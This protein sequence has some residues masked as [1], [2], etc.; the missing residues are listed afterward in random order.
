[1]SIQDLANIA[2]LLGVLV[3][4]IIFIIQSRTLVKVQ[5][6]DQICLLRLQNPSLL[7]YAKEWRDKDY[8]SMSDGERS[9]YHYGELIL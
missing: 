9:Y 3:T 7:N 5:R 6:A 4:L 8:E 1:M 2:A